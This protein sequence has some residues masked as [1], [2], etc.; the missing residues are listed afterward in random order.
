MRSGEG[1][2]PMAPEAESELH[3]RRY[4]RLAAVGLAPADELTLR[5]VVGS[6]GE[7]R[8]WVGYQAGVAGGWMQTEVVGDDGIRRS[9]EPAGTAPISP[10]LAAL[11]TPSPESSTRWTARPPRR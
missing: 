1:R 10:T 11:A 9:R 2:A 4:A 7:N 3:L 8:G 6:G 5:G